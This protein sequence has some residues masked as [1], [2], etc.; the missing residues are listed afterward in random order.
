MKHPEPNSVENLF[1]SVAPNY[2]YLNDLLSFGLHRVWKRQLLLWLDPGQGQYW[3]D[4][5]CGTGDL[6]IDLARLVRPGGSV[7]GV[8]SAEQTLV[9]ARSRA[10]KVSWL[11]INWMRGD[12]LDTGLPSNEFDGAVMAYGLR[13]LSDPLAGLVELRRLLRPGA[14]AGVLDFNPKVDGSLGA[15][16]QQFY[17]RNFVVPVAAN[18]GLESQ[19]AYLEESLK[20]FPAGAVQVKL[21]IEAGFLEAYHRPLAVGQMGALLLKA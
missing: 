9:L 19:Y 17:L 13:N 18:S 4:L 1:N 3:L 8:D 14:R 16:F 5:C 21:A 12:A 7:L 6:A 11:P 2:D 15:R 20:R 10:M